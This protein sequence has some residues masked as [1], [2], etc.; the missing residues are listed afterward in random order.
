MAQS[1]AVFD[2]PVANQFGI[3]LNAINNRG[4]VT[5][6]FFDVSLRGTARS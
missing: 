5:G 4:D 1:F 6:F 2:P 3:N